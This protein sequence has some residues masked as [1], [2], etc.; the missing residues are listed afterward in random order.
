MFYLMVYKLQSGC[1]RAY[2]NICIAYTAQD[3]IVRAMQQLQGSV[4]SGKLEPTY[5]RET[6]NAILTVEN[7]SEISESILEKALDTRASLPVDMLIRTSGEHR[8]SDFLLW[9]V[10]R[11]LLPANLQN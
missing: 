3:E 6:K 1:F 4:Q 7:F 10:R 8:L 9:Q 11:S 2:L 5:V